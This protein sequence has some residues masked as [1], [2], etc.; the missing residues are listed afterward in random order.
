MSM[1][2]YYELSVQKIPSAKMKL[3]VVLV[4]VAAVLGCIGA[5]VLSAIY[6][7]FEIGL[8]TCLVLI[9]AANLFQKRSK[10]EY[11]YIFSDGTF[12]ADKIQNKSRRFSVTKFEVPDVID[13]GRYDKTVR[14]SHKSTYIYDQSLEGGNPWFFYYYI[15][16]KKAL[17]IF[18]PDETML[19]LVKNALPAE[20][21][22]AA[23]GQN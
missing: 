20:L 7:L 6:I 23:F 12:T 10:G 1:E 8:P 16:N 5:L 9:M 13:F 22:R 19:E 11:E 21:Q 2:R 4:W 17:L 14:S 3:Y 18:E 15:N